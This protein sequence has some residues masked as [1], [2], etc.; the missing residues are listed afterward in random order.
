MSAIW[1]ENLARRLRARRRELGMPETYL[2][3]ITG[4]SRTTVRRVL[5]DPSRSRVR[6]IVLVAQHLRLNIEV[7][8]DERQGLP[9][10][11]Q[12]DHSKDVPQRTK[13]DAVRTGA[14]KVL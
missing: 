12:G 4:L 14:A 11:R 3:S 2:A 10:M 7:K 9:D 1:I 5:T 6:T 13:R 8:I